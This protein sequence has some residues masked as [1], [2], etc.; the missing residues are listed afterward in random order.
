MVCCVVRLRSFRRKK[1]NTRQES[2]N[3]KGK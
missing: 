3:G 2:I 1:G